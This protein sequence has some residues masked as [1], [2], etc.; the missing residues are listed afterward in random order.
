MAYSQMIRYLADVVTPLHTA[1]HKTPFQ[2]MNAEQ[3]A[4]DFLKKMLTKVLV[5]QPPNWGKQFH[6]FVNA[7]DIAIRSALM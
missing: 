5:V 3:D 6:V 7:S 1:V 2:W 4:Y